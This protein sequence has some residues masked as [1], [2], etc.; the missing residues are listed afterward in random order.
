MSN[1]FA[2]CKKNVENGRVMYRYTKENEQSKLRTHDETVQ[3]AIH[4]KCGVRN[5]LFDG[6]ATVRYN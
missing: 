1:L 2:C 4:S 5:E 3:H 6:F